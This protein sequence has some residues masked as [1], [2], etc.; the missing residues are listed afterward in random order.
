MSDSKTDAPVRKIVRIYAKAGS[1]GTMRAALRD[2]Q[3]ATRREDGCR[4]FTFFQSL[5]EPGAFLLM[6]DFDNVTALN[7]HMALPHTQA[8][9]ALNLA[10]AITPLDAGWIS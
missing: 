4:E 10:A 1:E 7:R 3:D 9:F 8:F 5:S 6:E 2:L